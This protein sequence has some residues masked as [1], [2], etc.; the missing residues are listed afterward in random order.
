[1]RLRSTLFLRFF[2]V[3]IASSLS[4]REAAS[5]SITFDLGTSDGSS[6][7]NFLDDDIV[8]SRETSWI[9]KLL[10]RPLRVP[11]ILRERITFNSYHATH[12]LIGSDMHLKDTLSREK[13]GQK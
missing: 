11:F 6:T 5:G 3:S 4:L 8:L 2:G 1:M 13:L 7:F 10:S 9:V 12:L